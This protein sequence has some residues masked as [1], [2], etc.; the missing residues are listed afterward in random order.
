MDI[1]TT[2][3]FRYHNIKQLNKNR[4]YYDYAK[5][6]I[7]T[8]CLPKILFSANPVLVSTIQLIDMKLIMLFKYIDKLRDF[9][10]ISSYN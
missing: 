1:T 6:G 4:Y 2:S 3:D 9:K 8:R 7:L 5:Y 10:K